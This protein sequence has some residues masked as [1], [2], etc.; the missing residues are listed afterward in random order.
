[1]IYSSNLPTKHP[2]YP[3]FA[4]KIPL[5]PKKKKTMTISISFHFKFP[6]MPVQRIFHEHIC[7]SGMPRVATSCLSRAVVVISWHLSPI[8][9]FG[10]SSPRFLASTSTKHQ[11]L[12]KSPTVPANLRN[13]PSMSHLIS[14]LSGDSVLMWWLDAHLSKLSSYWLFG[15]PRRIKLPLQKLPQETVWPN[16]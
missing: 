9:D 10:L 2:Y 12:T 5:K 1:M 14:Y 3:H 8:L 6:S 16:Y 15:P 4:Q 7:R 11:I 13:F